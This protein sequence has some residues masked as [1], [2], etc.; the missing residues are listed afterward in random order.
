MSSRRLTPPSV[1]LV[2]LIVFTTL[3]QNSMEYPH[4]IFWSDIP[5]D[6]KIYD[7]GQSW[8]VH[9]PDG[10]KGLVYWTGNDV[11][12]AQNMLK[13]RSLPKSMLP[14]PTPDMPN[15]RNTTKTACGKW[16]WDGQPGDKCVCGVPKDGHETAKK[17][18]RC[19]KCGVFLPAA[20]RDRDHPTDCTTICSRC[21]TTYED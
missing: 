13:I 4:N 11:G 21:G 16:R 17:R 3:L 14:G 12:K 8:V 1:S 9:M 10:R 15:F 18:D 7:L 6:A 20:R 19:R 2:G 5:K